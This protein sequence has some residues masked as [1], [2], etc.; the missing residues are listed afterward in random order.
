MKVTGM[1][2]WENENREHWVQHVV[3][4]KKEV[5]GCGITTT[6]TTKKER[7]WITF[8]GNFSK[9]GVIRTKLG[10]F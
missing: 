3:E 1:W 9:Y 4:R 7:K 10:Q 2:L 8:G 6:T 5:I